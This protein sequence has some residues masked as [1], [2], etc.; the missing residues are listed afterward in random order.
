MDPQTLE[1][2]YRNY[3]PCNALCRWLNAGVE[4]ET[5]DPHYDKTY[6]ERR[7]FSFTLPGD[8]YCRHQSFSSADE[9]KNQLIHDKPEKFDIGAIWTVPP[10]RKDSMLNK[11]RYETIEREFVIDIDMTDYDKVRTCCSGAVVCQLCWKFLVVACKS[12][13]IALKESFGYTVNLWVY[14]GRRGVHC[15][16]SDPS[17][18]RLNDF[19]RKSLIEFLN[20]GP[21]SHTP[22]LQIYREVLRPR[23]EEI[24]VREQKLF[25]NQER[26]NECVEI[27]NNQLGAKMQFVAKS[28][29]EETWAEVSE[30]INSQPDSIVIDQ[31][32][33]K[34]C[35]KYL[36]PRLDVH[37]SMAMN[38]LLKSPFSI[39]PKTG[40]VCVPFLVENVE[41]F[42]IDKVPNLT[43]LCEG[44]DNLEPYVEILNNVSNQLKECSRIER[45]KRVAALREQNTKF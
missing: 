21:K 42:Q 24:I 10:K 16:V 5:Q 12:M 6:F 4:L 26:L 1:N 30:F 45:S 29:S 8:I 31:I 13:D 28:T 7:E 35:F 41:E 23:F 39:H 22:F 37:V 19:R 40:N 33:Q 25:E 2:Y 34:I 32:K 17:A 14:S 18:R 20:S 3:F 27:I 9:F 15:W 36:Y 11:I 44:I 43:S 38:H